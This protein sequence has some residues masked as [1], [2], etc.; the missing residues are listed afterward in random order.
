MIEYKLTIN[1]L[2]EKQYLKREVIF[3]FVEICGIVDHHCLN[4]LFIR[5]G[6]IPPTVMPMSTSL[7]E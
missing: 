7:T 1:I 4:F 2:I 6:T 5:W 3:R